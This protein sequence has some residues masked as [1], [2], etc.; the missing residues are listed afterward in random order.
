[1]RLRI[2]LLIATIFFLF[3]ALVM[4][5]AGPSKSEGLPLICL[6]IAA[7]I[8]WHAVDS[9]SPKLIWIVPAV[10]SWGAGI[11]LLIMAALIYV[12]DA[13][14]LLAQGVIIFAMMF[15]CWAMRLNRELPIG[16]E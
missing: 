2:F 9:W 3:L 5:T 12:F 4:M 11:A 10:L 7:V 15:L 16:M 14:L 8:S 6:F 1:M 13:S